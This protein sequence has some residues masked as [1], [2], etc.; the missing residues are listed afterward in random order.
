MIKYDLHDK[1]IAIG[2]VGEFLDYQEN[3]NNNVNTYN[4]SSQLQTKCNI[5]C[6]ND[7]CLRVHSH[8]QDPCQSREA[9]LVLLMLKTSYIEATQ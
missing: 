8:T 2:I 6:T 7:V 1:R 4:Y 9:Y 5:P 3:D